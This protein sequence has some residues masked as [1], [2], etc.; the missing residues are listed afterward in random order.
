[1]IKVLERLGILGT[2]LNILQAIYRK[3]KPNIELNIE[4]LKAF[5]P[6]LGTRQGCLLLLYPFNMVF[7]VPARAIR[8]QK[9]IKKIQLEREVKIS[10]VVG[11]VILYVSDPKHP[12]RKLLQLIDTFSKVL[13]YKIKT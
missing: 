9:K 5:P 3:P 7:Q 12:T 13:G 1:M 6:K 10:L 4:H 2:Q 11:D 8:Q